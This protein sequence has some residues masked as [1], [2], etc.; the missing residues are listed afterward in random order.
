M[1][2]LKV[3]VIGGG[4]TYTPELIEGF[5]KRRE[6]LPVSRITLVDIDEERL[7]VVGGLA[8]RMMERAAAEIEVLLTTDR[9]QALEE[10][11]FVITQLRV[12]GLEGRARDERIPLEFDIIA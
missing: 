7:D 2:G 6:E 1:S 5:I 11:D 12:G 3:G 8:R 4:S 10:A 9:R